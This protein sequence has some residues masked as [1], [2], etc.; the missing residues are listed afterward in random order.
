MGISRDQAYV[1]WRRY[2]AQG[3][4]GLEERY[5]PPH[6]SPNRTRP[7]LEFKVI[8]FRQ[9]KALGPARL[10]GV[11]GLLASTVHQVLVR[12]QL[13]RLD[14]L[15]RITRGPDSAHDRRASR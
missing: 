12:H 11:V 10:V 2:R 14:H 15:D 7:S 9:K 8:T 6:R 5:S 1:W 3:V 13:N 4:A